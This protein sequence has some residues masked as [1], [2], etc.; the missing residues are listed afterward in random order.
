MSDIVETPSAIAVVPP[1]RFERRVLKH[2]GLLIGTAV[3][4]GLAVLVWLKDRSRR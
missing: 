4:I 1:S 3:G 2:K